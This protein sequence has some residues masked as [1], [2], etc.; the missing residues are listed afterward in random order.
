MC[1]QLIELPSSKVSKIFAAIRSD[2]PSALKKLVDSSD[3]RI[4]PVKVQITQRASIDEAAK[5][6]GEKLGGQG[7]DVL[8]NNAGI[9]PLTLGPIETMTEETLREAFDVN[10][11]AVHNVIAAFLPLLKKGQEKKIVTV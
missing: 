6:V 7:L 5:V 3:G 2:P 4:I 8:I 11:V 10:V 1:K 9:L